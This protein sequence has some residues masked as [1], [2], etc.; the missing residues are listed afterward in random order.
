VS[1]T[2][3]YS[4]RLGQPAPQRIESTPPTQFTPMPGTFPSPA[5]P[6]V[7]HPAS[8]QFQAPQRF[9]PTVNWDDLD[10]EQKRLYV[11]NN[12]KAGAGNRDAQTCPECG[13]GNL[14][15]RRNTAG[16]RTGGSFPAPQCYDCGW[17]VVQSGSIGGALGNG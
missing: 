14:F 17:P 10:Q 11:I 13:S 9:E 8:H 12:P 7:P 16:I 4:K 2:D 15:S 3:W 6:P 1:D 5:A